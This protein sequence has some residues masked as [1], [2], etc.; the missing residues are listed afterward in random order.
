[1]QIQQLLSEAFGSFATGFKKLK[2]AVELVDFEKFEL[3]KEEKKEPE[4]IIEEPIKPIDFIVNASWR[5][6]TIAQCLEACLKEKV[7]ANRF[8]DQWVRD[9]SAKRGWRKISEKEL[10]KYYEEAWAFISQCVNI[11][12]VIGPD[13]NKDQ[14]ES[15]FNIHVTDEQWKFRQHW[16]FSSLTMKKFMKHC[17]GVHDSLPALR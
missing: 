1:M 17:R 13:S 16:F 14:W 15:F 12:L 3:P 6:I 4:E 11:V 8:K 7:R 10:T 5:H 2:K 9:K